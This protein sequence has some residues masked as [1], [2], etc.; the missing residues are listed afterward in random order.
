M[1]C[2]ALII[3]SHPSE[4]FPLALQTH[5]KHCANGAARS[6]N[7][8]TKLDLNQSMRENFS[9][10]HKTYRNKV[11]LCSLPPLNTSN[12]SLKFLTLTPETAS[13]AIQKSKN[14]L[15][16]SEGVMRLI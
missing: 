12:L 3:A 16:R 13:L 4:P 11:K 6:K 15:P 7:V 5:H 2:N 10:M 14:G 8:K 9:A 1:E